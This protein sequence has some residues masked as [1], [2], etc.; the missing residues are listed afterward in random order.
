MTI[1]KAVTDEE[2]DQSLS[3]LNAGEVIPAPEFAD[4]MS[5]E[6]NGVDAGPSTKEVKQLASAEVKLIEAVIEHP[7]RPSSEYAK[8]AGISPNTLRRIR[9]ELVKRGFIREHKLQSVIRGRAAILL[10][11]LELAKQCVAKCKE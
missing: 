5:G 9:P 3:S 7:M 10:E 2:V 1:R 4:W 11:P 8:L 6:Q